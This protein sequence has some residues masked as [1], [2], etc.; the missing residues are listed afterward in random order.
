M[1][2]GRGPGGAISAANYAVRF[3]DLIEKGKHHRAQANLG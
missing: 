3:V 2:R 1:H